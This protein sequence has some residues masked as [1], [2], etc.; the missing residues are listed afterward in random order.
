MPR[1]AAAGLHVTVRAN[2]ARLDRA[3]GVI[4]A[5]AEQIVRNSAQNISD[6]AKQTAPVDTGALRQ[7]IYLNDGDAST[8]ATSVSVARQ[9][10]PDAQIVN[11]VDPEFAISLSHGGSSG[12]TVVVGAGVNYAIYQEYGTRHMRAQPFMIPS[13]E[14]ERGNF[15][16]AMKHVA[17]GV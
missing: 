12:Y 13:A 3:G 17:D 15:E 8:Y 9:L 7:S 5:A 1:R 4:K 16:D 2:T 10:N 11:E 14:S 6:R